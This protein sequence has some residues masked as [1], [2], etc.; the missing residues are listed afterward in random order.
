MADSTAD[1]RAGGTAPRRSDGLQDLVVV[2]VAVVAAAV[3]VV[4]LVAISDSEPNPRDRLGE[5]TDLAEAWL[6]AWEADDR[7]A[8]GS[9]VVDPGVDPAPALAAFAD[10]LGVFALD[11]EAGSPSLVAD[12]ASVPFTA[13]VE[14]PGAGEWTFEGALPLA[15][16][17][18]PVGDDGRVTARQWRVA[19]SPAVLHPDLTPGRRLQLATTWPARGSLQFT[20][21]VPIPASEPLRSI[22]GSV[23]PATAVQVAELGAPYEPGRP[24]GQRGLQASLERPLAGRPTVEVQVRAGERVVEVLTTLAGAP[25]ADVR[26]T[27]DQ[28]ILEAAAAAL[29]AAGNPAALVAIQPSTGA[30]RA[31]ANRPPSGFGRALAGRY[32]PGSTFKVVTTAALLANGVTAETRIDCPD[33]TTVNGRRIRNAEGEALGNV[34]FREAFFRSCNTAFVQLA[35]RIPGQALVDAARRFGFGRDPLL[36]TGSATSQFPDPNGLVDQAAAAIGQG[37]VLATPMQ[38]ASVAAT[39]AAGGYRAPHL[40]EVPVVEFDPMEPGHAATLQE[41][42]RLVVAQGTGTRARLP[43]APVAGKTG[44]AEFGTASPLRTHAWFI[45]FRGDLAVAVVVED[46]GFGGEVAAPIAADFFRRVG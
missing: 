29:G 26:T 41:L 23:G 6:A 44:T 9:L 36:G 17:E 33:E 20:D 8:L 10:G 28:R 22:T 11:A 31:A 14:L 34:A 19:F 3:V 13:T 7:E 12:G 43:G 30:V 35:T 5:A 16:V 1:D 25:G 24:V 46:G 45:G 42:M 37:R 32:P 4:G 27:L 38:M 21:G 40:V 2:L 18:V 39:V 15:D